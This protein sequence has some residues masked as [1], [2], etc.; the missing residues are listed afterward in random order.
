MRRAAKTHGN[1]GVDRPLDGAGAERR[2]QRSGVWP[3][4]HLRRARQAA[5][6]TINLLEP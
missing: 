5:K 2:D 6:F 3:Q 1:P 4:P